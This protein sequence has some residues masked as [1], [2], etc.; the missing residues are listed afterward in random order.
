MESGDENDMPSVNFAEKQTTSGTDNKEDD[1]FEKSLDD[2]LCVF[3]S[4]GANTDLLADNEAQIL[5]YVD[6][7]NEEI[8][9]KQKYAEEHKGDDG[10]GEGAI[11]EKPHPMLLNQYPICKNH[12][13]FLL[14][15][16]QSF[17]QVVSD[18]L[19]LLLLQL[20]KVANKPTLRL[21]YN[22]M[23][24]DC[25]INN[26]HFHVLETDL[27]FGEGAEQFP[28]ESADKSLFFTSTL[29]HKD[30]E[31]INMYNC[32]VRFGE[33]VG[34]PMKTLLISPNIESDE[35]SLE[36]A[37]EALAHTAGVVLN[38]LIDQNIPHNILVADEGMTLYIIPRKFDMLIEGVQFFTSF[39]SLCG[40][41]KFKTENAFNESNL[42][43]IS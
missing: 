7:D 27:L 1:M 22:S 29:K 24:A 13:L 25:I 12:S 5:F 42:E 6:L 11:D 40:Y 3:K 14:F 10:D 36:D 17:P 28:I 20:F 33:V 31:E 38:Y 37:Q 35:T 15:A 32:G 8:I 21:G 18:E 34:W 30:E 16:E 19:I 43:T 2:A 9:T 4:G 39:E 23:G 41:V 26:L